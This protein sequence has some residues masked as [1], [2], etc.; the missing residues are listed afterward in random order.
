MLLATGKPYP[1]ELPGFKPAVRSHVSRCRKLLPIRTTWSYTRSRNWCPIQENATHL[2]YLVLKS[3]LV[4][5][6]YYSFTVLIVSGLYIYIYSPCKS[7]AWHL[8]CLSLIMLSIMKISTG[9]QIVYVSPRTLVS[10]L[11]LSLKSWYLTYKTDC[12]KKKLSLII[13]V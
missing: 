6:L 11:S 12:V 10:N 7:L 4:F 3:Q 8:Y 5:M 13:I 1:F 2:N 9:S